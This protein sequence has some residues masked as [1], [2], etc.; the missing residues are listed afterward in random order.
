MNFYAA[1]GVKLNPLTGHQTVSQ[2]GTF[3]VQ[4]NRSVR[5]RLDE[6]N[7]RFQVFYRRM[8]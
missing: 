1:T 3:G 2:L 6:L 8:R 5:P 7:R 4:A